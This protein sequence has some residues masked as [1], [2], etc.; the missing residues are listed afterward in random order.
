MMKKTDAARM[1]RE[2]MHSAEHA[3][4]AARSAYDALRR[5]GCWRGDA[6]LVAQKAA[7]AAQLAL[8]V[9]D[10]DDQRDRAGDN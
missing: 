2:A 1:L 9:L 10:A 6:Q 3:R 5:G 7:T 4:L 8:A